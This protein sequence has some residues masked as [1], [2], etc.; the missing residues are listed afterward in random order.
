MT[1]MRLITV[2]AAA[3]SLASCGAP[4]ATP[5]APASQSAQ[6]E[7]PAPQSEADAEPSL[8]PLE[9]AARDVCAA[10]DD[11]FAAA[12]P[13]GAAFASR[14]PDARVHA[15]WN[16]DGE[17][18]EAIIYTPS[19][20]DEAR[21]AFDG[22]VADFVRR[23]LVAGVDRTGLTGA[24]RY[25]DGRFCVVQTEAVAI[26]PFQDAVQTAQAQLNE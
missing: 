20:S 17:R 24:Y 14:G 22:A 18:H 8:A 13:D 16:I 25:R 21:L 1:A 19:L 7:A 2:F 9:I 12:L 10:G 23:N 26:A 11:G 15:G 4:D 5:E 3:L 6:A